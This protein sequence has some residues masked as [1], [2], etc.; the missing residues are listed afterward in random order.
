[1]GEGGKPGNGDVRLFDVLFQTWKVGWGS[2]EL[3]MPSFLGKT[4]GLL[5]RHT[6][7]SGPREHIIL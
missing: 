1:M 4:R 6:Y 7:A 3:F 5:I 2:R